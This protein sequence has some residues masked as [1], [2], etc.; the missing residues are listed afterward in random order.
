MIKEI[1]EDFEAYKSI[2]QQIMQLIQKGVFYRNER[3]IQ[4]LVDTEG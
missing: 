3:Y 2:H 1:K 4:S